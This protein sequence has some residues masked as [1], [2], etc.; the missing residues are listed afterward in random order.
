MRKAR[1]RRLGLTPREDVVPPA[2][3][4]S[5]T[6]TVPMSQGKRR[7]SKPASDSAMSAATKKRKQRHVQEPEPETN[8]EEEEEVEDEGEEDGED[9]EGEEGEEGEGDEH[10]GPGNCSGEGSVSDGEGKSLRKKVGER[11]YSPRKV[12]KFTKR[13]RISVKGAAPPVW[14]FSNKKLGSLTLVGII[15]FVQYLF[16][17]QRQPHDCFGISGDTKIFSGKVAQ[18]G[19]A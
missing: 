19:T 4:K 8:D 3:R 6:Q 12:N 18:G 9:E 2:K 5:A 10:G 16:V 17:F 1:L 7:G 11:T 15:L 13:R 14:K